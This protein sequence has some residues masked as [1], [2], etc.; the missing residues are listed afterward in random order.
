MAEWIARSEAKKRGLNAEFGSAGISP[1]LRMS[2]N[3]RAAVK[4]I[5]GE[6]AGHEPRQITRELFDSADLVIG[7]TQA[8]A[9]LLRAV[10]G[11]KDGLIAM[12]DDVPDPFGGDEDEYLACAEAIRA[13]IIKLMDGGV[14]RD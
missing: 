10:F 11:D 13:G 9:G 12:P 8:H 2:E 4:A 7:L 6:D 14:I 3:A 5:T 1:G